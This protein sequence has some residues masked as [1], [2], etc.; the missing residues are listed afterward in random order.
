MSAQLIALTD[1]EVDTLHGIG[2]LGFHVY[3]LLRTF[4]DYGT[5]IVGRSRPISLAML[6][7]YTETHTRRGAGVQ[8]E[9]PSEK[10]LRNALAKL[11]RAGL[12]RRLPGDRLVFSLP[13][14]LTASAR[15]IQTGHDAGTKSSTNPG[16]VQPAPVLAEPVTPGTDA[17]AQQRPNRAHIKSHVNKNPTARP[18][19]AVDKPAGTSYGGIAQTLT[20]AWFPT[21]RPQKAKPGFAE[22]ARQAPQASAEESRLLAIG[23]QKGVDPRPGESWSE[24]AARLFKRNPAPPPAPAHALREVR[25]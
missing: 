6:A 24:F 2:S 8:I 4:A 12:L 21:G 9:Q 10:T 11:E 23:R 22:G 1:R 17:A 14:A 5:G 3:V 20:Q 25:L 19:A 18:A 7:S 13:L 16:T 15:P